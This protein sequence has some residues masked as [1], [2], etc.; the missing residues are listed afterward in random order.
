M[1]YT[2]SRARWPSLPPSPRSLSSTPL[3]SLYHPQLR[4][5]S[6]AD[7]PQSLRS[8]A[9][10]LLSFLSIGSTFGELEALKGVLAAVDAAQATEEVG[11]THWC[12]IQRFMLEILF[13]GNSKPLH[14]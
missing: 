2:R 9:A 1:L 3:P 6:H 10:A 7:Q 5:A 8:A 11:S 14:K 4:E 13:L 12:M